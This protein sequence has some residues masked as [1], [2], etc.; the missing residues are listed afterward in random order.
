MDWCESGARVTVATDGSNDN[1]C[2][3]SDDCPL[4]AGGRGELR[5]VGEPEWLWGD[6]GSRLCMPSYSVEWNSKE[7]AVE[8]NQLD[9]VKDCC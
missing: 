2:I 7:S 6:S 3:G 1:G 4:R 9:M 8:K 5:G